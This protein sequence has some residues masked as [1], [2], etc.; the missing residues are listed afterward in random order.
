MTEA[1][2]TKGYRIELSQDPEDDSWGAEV[3]DLPGCVAAAASPGDAIAAAVDAIDAW[4]A[5]AIALGRAIPA[6]S[7]RTGGYSGRFVLRVSRGLH[8][9]LAREAEREGVSLNLYCATVLAE[10]VGASV[11]AGL[12]AA[13]RDR[14]RLVRDAMRS[15]ST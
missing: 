5:T 11:G 4:I 1:L 15:S 9:R 12:P 13:P 10:A 14:P 2:A 7:R 6:P 3:P 8:G